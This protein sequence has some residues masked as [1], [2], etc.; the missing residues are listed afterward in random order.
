MEGFW[1]GKKSSLSSLSGKVRKRV[2]SE[3]LQVKSKAKYASIPLSER[4]RPS[5]LDSILG[6]D[7]L[8]S[9]NSSLRSLAKAGKLPSCIFYGNPGCGKTTLA[10]ALANECRHCYEFEEISGAG[11]GVSDIKRIVEESRSKR[12]LGKKTILFVDEIHRFSKTQQD[13]LLSHIE[14]GILT[15]LGATTQNPSLD[16]TPALR[17]RCRLIALNK[18][19]VP[20]LIS[21]L[22][23]AIKTHYQ[24]FT[25]QMNQITNKCINQDDKG[26]VI[27]DD[28]E[29]F[30]KTDG[31]KAIAEY[32]NG[33]ARCALNLLEVVCASLTNAEYT[34][35]IRV[36][37]VIDVLKQEENN[38]DNS[39]GT[40]LIRV[41]MDK[42][43]DEHFELL[44]AFHKSMR[45]SDPDA[46]VFWLGRMLFS[47]VPPEI[48]ARRMIACASEDIGLADAQALPLAIS[49][50]QAVKM[51]GVPECEINLA[52]VCMYL[53]EAPKSIRSYNAYRNVQQMLRTNGDAHSSVPLHLRN[54]PTEHMKQLGYGNGYL[55]NPDYE[56]K[57]G[58]ELGQYYLPAPLAAAKISFQ[59]GNY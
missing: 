10:R 26:V 7:R 2:E 50:Y 35:S 14:S 5:T 20:V 45:G 23:S 59:D 16:L 57:S 46:S 28:I 58:K 40:K 38:S 54:A 17:S 42:Q 47:G 32:S 12:L 3:S 48:I 21:I 18:L 33:D 43:G 6:H 1:N 19:S 56:Y 25:P 44:S 24:Q 31:L 15:L 41:R 36:E 22:K 51:I 13:A 34:G 8:L 53:A 4:V 11:G 29:E 37:H 39:N 49:A 52:H 9:E 55:Y 30:E 27:I